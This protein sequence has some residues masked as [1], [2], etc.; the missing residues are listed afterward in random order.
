MKNVGRWQLVPALNTLDQG[1]LIAY[2]T[3]T[4]WGIGC[5]PY[6]ADA[7]AKIL[8]I[9]QR[10]LH[11]GLILVAADLQQLGPL[12]RG[13]TCEQ[14]AQVQADLPKPT[15]WLLPHH[16]AVPH[17]ICGA[18]DTVAVRISRHPTV[19]SL[20]RMFGGMIVSTSANRAG[21]KAAVNQQQA[22]KT[23]GSQIDTYLPGQAGLESTGSQIIHLLSGKIIRA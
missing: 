18:H 4:V 6:N 23:F 8:H 9:K 3:E 16:N 20:C 21:K 14:K 10:P 19:A 7:V 17:W 1:G 5:N 22:R 2:P 13:L 12:L 11:K 15:T